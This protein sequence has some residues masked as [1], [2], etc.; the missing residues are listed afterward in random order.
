MWVTDASQSGVRRLVR[1]RDRELA[2]R[3]ELI[4]LMRRLNSEWDSVRD[5]W[6][7]AVPTLTDADNWEKF[8][9]GE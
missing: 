7:A 2:L 1:D 6:R 4:G 3:S 8:F 5:R 9:E